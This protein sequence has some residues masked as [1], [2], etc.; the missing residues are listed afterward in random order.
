MKPRDCYDDVVARARRLLRLHDGLINRRRYRIRADWARRF[1]QLM[2]WPSSHVIGRVDSADA[3][4]VLRDG[5]NL[6]PD[7]FA[8]NAMDDLLRAA[9]TFGV[10]GLDRYVHERVVKGVV[11][12]LRAADLNRQQESF[13]IPVKVAIQITEE[14]AR[15]RREK[16]DVRPANE[17]R[18]AVQEM[19]H[20]RPLQS[21]REIEF[22][23][24][25]LGVT[26]LAGQL[27]RAY[28]LGAISP[29][30]DQLNKIVQKR[31]LIVHEGDLVRHQRGG[32]VRKSEISRKFVGDS[33]DFLDTFVSHLEQVNT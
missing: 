28:K 20:R 16:R 3:V 25:L 27:Q 23:F 13:S 2:H 14:V 19:L 8:A 6:G 29:I 5:A 11:G 4:I 24:E 9:L 21:W 17:I 33:L 12:A 7:D 31:N 30:K 18:K 32:R 26:D 22:A 15:A 1:R 10:S